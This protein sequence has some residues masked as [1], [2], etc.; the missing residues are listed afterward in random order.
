MSIRRYKRTD[1]WI[2]IMFCIVNHYSDTPSNCRNVMEY[3][4]YCSGTPHIITFTNFISSSCVLI[5]I[6]FLTMMTLHDWLSFWMVVLLLIT[7]TETP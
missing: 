3:V 1:G 2:C 7:Y 4:M 5:T 6:L